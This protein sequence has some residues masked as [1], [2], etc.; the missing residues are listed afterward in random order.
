MAAAV[1]AAAAAV[2]GT[3]VAAAAANGAVAAAEA[4]WVDPQQS[5]VVSERCE[6]RSPG[7]C[8]LGPESFV[9][10]SPPKWARCLGCPWGAV[11]CEEL[12]LLNQA[13]TGPW[14]PH[15]PTA[16][17]RRPVLGGKSGLT[18]RYTPEQLCCVGFHA[19]V[20]QTGSLLT[21]D[22]HQAAAE[23]TVSLDVGR[24]SSK[25]RGCCKLAVAQSWAP[26]WGGISC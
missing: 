18:Q 4:A 16:P 2:N 10:L 7:P 3:G 11:G 13:S 6:R 25:S 5:A 14:P 1:A 26:D 12:P 8:P 15:W 17:E 21:L 23:A 20:F 9:W 24:H 22:L 19:A